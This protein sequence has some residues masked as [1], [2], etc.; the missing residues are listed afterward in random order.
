MEA[1]NK[2]LNL[3]RL[4]PVCR[5]YMPTILSKREDITRHK[6]GCNGV[7]YEESR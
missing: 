3:G 7:N 1:K 4:E 2:R 5:K 6:Y